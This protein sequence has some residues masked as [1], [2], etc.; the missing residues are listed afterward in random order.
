MYINSRKVLI[1]T[2]ANTIISFD[3]TSKLNKYQVELV[4]TINKDLGKMVG[5]LYYYSMYLIPK[6]ILYL[7]KM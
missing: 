7:C 6:D 2:S 4:Y 3:M 5:D 1:K